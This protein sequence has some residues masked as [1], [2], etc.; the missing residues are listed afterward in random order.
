M[1]RII[2]TEFRKMKRYSVIW[3]GVAT[4]AAV[5]LLSCFMA[6]ASNAPE[7][8][9]SRFASNIIWNNLVLIYPATIVLIAGYIIERERTDDTLK[10][11]LTIPISFRKLLTGKLIAVGCMDAAFSV[12]EFFLTLIVFFLSGSSD[13]SVSGAVQVLLQMIGIN[14]LT[15]IA[16]MP[17]IAFTAQRGGSFMAGVGFAFFY[18]FVGMMASG[19]G[20]RDLYPITAGLTLIGYQDGSSE[21]GNVFISFTVILVL[22]LVTALVVMNAKNREVI[23][24]IKGKGKKK[25]TYKQSQKRKTR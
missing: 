22:L 15:Y 14:L 21:V 5:I 1:A 12:I 25:R 13:F 4:M 10:N 19:H 18:G 24:A 23:S 8:T 9:L 11:I 2:M 7:F 20:L 16:V 6:T 3:I 17:I